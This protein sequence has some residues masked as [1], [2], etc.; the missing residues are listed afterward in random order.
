VVRVAAEARHPWGR[1]ADDRRAAVRGAASEKRK[2]GGES[3]LTTR[4]IVGVDLGGGEVA[5]GE[6]E[7]MRTKTRWEGQRCFT[8]GGKARAAAMAQ[9]P[10]LRSVAVRVQGRG[11]VGAQL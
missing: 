2:V 11:G 10:E 1:T 9:R 8:D 7:T 4:R 5:T 3:F 6:K